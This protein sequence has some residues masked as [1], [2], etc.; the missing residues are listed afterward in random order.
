MTV[1]G[2]F[3]PGIFWALGFAAPPRIPL[4]GDANGDGFADLLCVYPAQAS[5]LDVCLTTPNGKASIPIQGLPSWGPNCVVAAATP[6]GRDNP[7]KVFAVFSDGSVQVAT[8]SINGRFTTEALPRLPRPLTQPAL[9]LSQ[10]EPRIYDIGTGIEWYLAGGKW[11]TKKMSHRF[12]PLVSGFGFDGKNRVGKIFKD[13]HRRQTLV[14]TIRGSG[15][16]SVDNASGLIAFAGQVIDTTPNGKP[17]ALQSPVTH[18]S[19]S[20]Y[21]FGDVDGDGDQDLFEFRYGTERDTRYSVILYRRISDDEVDSD[22]DGVSNIEESTIGSNKFDPDTDGDG[23][24]DGWELGEYRGLKLR[25]LGCSPIHLDVV[26][27]LSRFHQVDEK[28]FNEQFQRIRQ[29]YAS[30]PI[31]NIDGIP[32]INLHTIDLAAVPEDQQKKGWPELR[33]QYR[34]NKWRG[35][36]HWMQVTPWG[37]GQA[38][39]LGDGGGCGGGGNSLYATFIHEFGHQLGLPHE[40]FYGPPWCPTYGSLMNYAYSYSFE[41]DGNKIHYSDGRLADFIL[42]ESNLSEVIPLPYSQVSFLEKGPYRYRLKPNGATTLIDWNWNGIFGEQNVRAD[43]NYSYSTHAGPREDL[44][45]T[46]AAP[47][48]FTHASTAYLIFAKHNFAA[49]TKTDPTVSESRPGTLYIRRMSEPRK[50]DASTAITEA[51]VT[52]DPCA[53]SLRDR[54]LTAF[55]TAKGIKLATVIEKR[56][57]Y[58]VTKEVLIPQTDHCD[59][60][61]FH[62]QLDTIVFIWNRMNRRIGYR[63]VDASLN[64]GK[65]W[66][67]PFLSETPVGATWD[68]FREELILGIMQNQDANRPKRFQIRRFA[69]E[70]RLIETSMEWIEG[71]GGGARGSSRPVLVFVDDK[72]AGKTGKLLYFALGGISDNAPWSCCYVAEQVEDK[73]KSGGWLVKRYYDEWTQSRSGPAACKLGDDVLY[74]YRWVDGGQ[75]PSDNTLHLGYNGLGIESSPMADFNDLEYIRTFGLRHSIIYQSFR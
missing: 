68:P 32:G 22:G 4:V 60:A 17:L 45:K 44:G 52:G 16:A 54:I 46:D 6:G 48:L 26:C 74:A 63:F 57:R 15:G 3:A 41:D 56:S 67:L 23:L 20:Q 9:T 66:I 1:L 53:V 24:L 19:S 42:N 58:R 61:L 33:N 34:P 50:W 62:N 38:D 10:G 51:E 69:I 70:H 7:C 73:T 59:V 13:E 43:I 25:E 40:G 8:G 27:L 28:F 31:R 11:I 35:V 37:G 30:L 72:W 47:W 5:I 21:C 75:G 39:Q 12:F 2:L 64:I 55:P 14:D 18:S 65:E 29:Y 36:V 71:V 49:D